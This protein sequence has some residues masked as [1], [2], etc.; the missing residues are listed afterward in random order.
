MSGSGRNISGVSSD[1]IS[2]GNNVSRGAGNVSEDGGGM[3]G[4]TERSWVSVLTASSC[5]R[6]S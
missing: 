2:S 4:G 5:R 3:N 1:V 6:G